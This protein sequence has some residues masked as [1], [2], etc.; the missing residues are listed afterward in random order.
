MGDDTSKTIVLVLDSQI[1][2]DF[3]F[4]LTFL[5]KANICFCLCFS[6]FF[7]FRQWNGFSC[8]RF[9]AFSASFVFCFF[10]WEFMLFSSSGTLVS[11]QNSVVQPESDTFPSTKTTMFSFHSRSFLIQNGVLIRGEVCNYK[12][13]VNSM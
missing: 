9:V 13:Y 2:R 12:F 6:W 7:G 4:W 11:H 1:W 5:R 8:L 3:K 10:Y